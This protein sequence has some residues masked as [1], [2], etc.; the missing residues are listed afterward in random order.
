M[1]EKNL[2]YRGISKDYSG[3]VFSEN[4]KPSYFREREY[5]VSAEKQHYEEALDYIRKINVQLNRKNAFEESGPKYALKVLGY[6][7]HYGFESRLLDVSSNKMV[8]EYF[9]CCEN[10]SEDGYVV[11]FINDNIAEKTPESKIAVQHKLRD[12]IKVDLENK[13]IQAQSKHIIIDYTKTCKTN[14]T[15][16]RYKKQ[17]GAFI[18]FCSDKESIH[19]LLQ[20]GI[21]YNKKVIPHNKKIKQLIRLSKNGFNY[22]ELFPDSD[23]SINVMM[24]Y[25]KYINGSMTL[26]SIYKKKTK[27]ELP[28]TINKEELEIILKDKHLFYL[29]FKEF[30]EIL[31]SEEESNFNLLLKALNLKKE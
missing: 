25:D 3:G 22:V 27:K 8:A 1:A 30:V 12:L 23:D 19:Y 31:I 17:K 18:L 10:F 29:F 7:Q 13:R 15:N 20:E 6:I 26:E 4:F 16:L 14:S 28:K 5:D 21:D 2:Y 24:L 11:S 9:A